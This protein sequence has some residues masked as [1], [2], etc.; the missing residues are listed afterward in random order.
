MNT[1]CVVFGEGYGRG[2]NRESETPEPGRSC[3]FRVFMLFVLKN[4]RFAWFWKN[5]IA[6]FLT[7]AA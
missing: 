6:A 2:V 3:D 5:T 4:C 1:N 7:A